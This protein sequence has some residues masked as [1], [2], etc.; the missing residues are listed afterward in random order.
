MLCVLMCSHEIIRL[1]LKYNVDVNLCSLRHICAV[2][3][4][5]FDSIVIL[6]IMFDA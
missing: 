5:D 4:D 6:S 3:T 2:V 1:R